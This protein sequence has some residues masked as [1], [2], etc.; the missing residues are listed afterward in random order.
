MT[1]IIHP[2]L[3]LLFGGE[4]TIMTSPLDIHTGRKHRHSM[5]STLALA[6]ALKTRLT[7]ER[8]HVC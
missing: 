5:P 7:D 4:K 6:H 3:S 1:S 8:T 2:S